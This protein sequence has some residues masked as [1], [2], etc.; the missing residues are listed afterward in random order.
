M[1]RQF[2]FLERA[3]KAAGGDGEAGSVL[4]EYSKFKK[5]INKRNAGKIPVEARKRVQYAMIPFGL[6][7]D[8]KAATKAGKHRFTISVYSNTW[9]IGKTI[10]NAELGYETIDPENTKAANFYPAVA[11]VFVP[12]GT[13]PVDQTSGITKRKYKA[14]PGKSYS[15]PFG[16]LIGKTTNDGY[17]EQEASL[18]KAF[19][20]AG[21][22]S[23]SFVPEKWTKAIEDV[24]AGV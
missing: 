16:A 14:L 15:I 12:D 19:V 6:V 22:R 13:V 21:A 24:P 5:G 7:D 2:S 20:A 9:R 3:L 1:K 18:S 8:A 17:L 11:K 23:V 10:G 4:A